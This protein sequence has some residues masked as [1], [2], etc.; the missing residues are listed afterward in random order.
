[1]SIFNIVTIVCLIG[2]LIMAV[3]TLVER[4]RRRR[5]RLNSAS[6]RS[7]RARANTKMRT[8]TASWPGPF[9]EAEAREY[10]ASLD[11]R[12]TKVLAIIQE[13]DGWYVIFIRGSTSSLRESFYVEE[14]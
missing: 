10:A 1:M 9:T 7:K 3:I 6:S 12:F 11:D 8:E 2:M 5:R 13:D 14:G 4:R